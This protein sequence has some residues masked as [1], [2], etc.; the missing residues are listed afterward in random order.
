MQF[1][2]SFDCIKWEEMAEASLSL[3]FMEEENE[4]VKRLAH[5]CRFNGGA[6]TRL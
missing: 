4:K 2:C 5:N 3:Q 6:S 1:T